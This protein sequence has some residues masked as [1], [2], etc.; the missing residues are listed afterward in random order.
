MEAKFCGS[1]R[2][3]MNK[4]FDGGD[5]GAKRKI[6][7]ISTMLPVVPKDPILLTCT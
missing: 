5:F 1:L 2:I 6:T 7:P 3:A 4:K